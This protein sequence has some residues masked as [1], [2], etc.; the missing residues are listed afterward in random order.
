MIEIVS[1]RIAHDRNGRAD[2]SRWANQRPCLPYLYDQVLVPELKPGDGVVMDNLGSHKGLGVRQ[3]IA[4]LK[5]EAVA[6][7]RGVATRV[8]RHG[9]VYWYDTF[10]VGS[11]VRK[12]HIGEDSDEI[13]ARLA[14]HAELAVRRQEAQAARAR[15]IRVLRAEGFLGVD[16]AT[17]ALLNAFAQA[18]VFRLGATI[19][20][21]QAFRLY[22][23]ELGLRYTF[24][25]PPK[26]ATSTSPA[27][28]ACRS[29]STTRRRRRCNPF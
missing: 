13:R 12:A 21:T 17:G 22:E 16:G 19:V 6:D 24:D 29:R 4:S 15:T 11:N 27:F 26:P 5:D 23:G 2:D 3:A 25:Q 8:E 10:R 1:R 28:R 20:G 9:K 14:R 7:L 18:G